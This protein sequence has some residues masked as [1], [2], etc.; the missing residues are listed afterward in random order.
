MK[1]AFLLL[2]VLWK[3]STD[4]IAQPKVLAISGSL[5]HGIPGVKVGKT[6]TEPLDNMVAVITW[7]H[8]VIYSTIPHCRRHDLDDFTF[9]A[10]Y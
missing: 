2:S 1:L 9:W 5:H 6:N 10:W 8:K 3:T 7:L 4:K